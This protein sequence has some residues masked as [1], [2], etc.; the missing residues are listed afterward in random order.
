M[1]VKITVKLGGETNHISAARDTIPSSP[2]CIRKWAR[3]QHETTCA[4][5]CAE[6]C[7]MCIE[8][9]TRDMPYI[10][11]LDLFLLCPTSVLRD[12]VHACIRNYESPSTIAQT[13]VRPRL[14]GLHLTVP[15]LIKET[16]YPMR[17]V[18]SLSRMNKIENSI[19]N[20]DENVEGDV[21]CN[22]RF[23]NG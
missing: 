7:P 4:R 23:F 9:S 10:C 2:Y 19:E 5:A 8:E 20:R 17:Y 13:Y 22:T 12:F 15:G 18:C 6:L 11:Q 3:I 1:K 16:V 21:A 14:P